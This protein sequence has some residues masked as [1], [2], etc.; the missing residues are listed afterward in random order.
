LREVAVPARTDNE[1]DRP[2]QSIAERKNERRQVIEDTCLMFWIA[3]F[4]YELKD[5]EFKSGIISGL[6]VLG[7]DTQNGSWKSALSYTL[8]LS[9]TVAVIR[10]LVV[11]RA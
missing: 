9:A 2:T 7:I 5:N 8:I 3:M 1:D 6:V 11:Y 10:A 4:D